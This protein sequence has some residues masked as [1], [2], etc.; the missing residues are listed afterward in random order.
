MEEL[1]DAIEDAQYVNAIS[2]QEDGPRPVVAWEVP[3]AE[4][5]QAWEARNHDLTSLDWVLG[6]AI[7]FFLFSSFIKKGGEVQPQVDPASSLNSSAPLHRP[8]KKD[9]VRINFCEEILR[10]KRLQEGRPRVDRARYIA[11]MY[12]AK[13]QY[14]DGE[15]ANFPKATE[16][17]EFDLI[18]PPSTT[19]ASVQCMDFPTCSE[20]LVGLRGVVYKELK[21]GL[22]ALVLGESLAKTESLPTVTVAKE[23]AEDTHAVSMRNLKTSTRMEGDFFDA[24]EA[25]VM[26]SLKRDYFEAF[27]KS[28]EYKRLKNFLWYQDRRVVAEDFYVMR[29]LGR[30]GFGLVT[31]TFRGNNT[32]FQLA[33]SHNCLQLAKRELLASCTP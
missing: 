23:S 24:A 7:G 21:Q 20:S 2:T 19:H 18:R 4:E 12:L 17:D 5:L 10:W 6:S 28:S 9:Y 33:D 31:G 25:V 26:E 11:D 13:P 14:Q 22:S 3:S 16:I 29:V 1:Q 30:G 8:R 15:I 32:C 27:L